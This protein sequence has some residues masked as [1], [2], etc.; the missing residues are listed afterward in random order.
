[1]DDNLLCSVMFARFSIDENEDDC[2]IFH[3][4]PI[5]QQIDAEWGYITNWVAGCHFTKKIRMV[6]AIRMNCDRNMDAGSV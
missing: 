1:M 4:F 3:Y 2:H 5:E 6:E